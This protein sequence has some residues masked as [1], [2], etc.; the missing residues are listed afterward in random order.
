MNILIG[1]MIIAALFF[2][3]AT[4]EKCF[5]RK[6]AFYLTAAAWVG[7]AIGYLFSCS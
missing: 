1:Y 6:V 7:A 2:I 5:Y 3:V 4:L